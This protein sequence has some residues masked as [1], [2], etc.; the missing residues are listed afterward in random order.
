MREAALHGP[1]DVLLDHFRAPRFLGTLSLDAEDVGTGRAG[2]PEE[3]A[4]VRMQIRLGGAGPGLGGEGRVRDVRFK[5]FGCPAT[6]A[7]ASWT[8]ERVHGRP[9]VEAEALAVAEISRVLDLDPE[10]QRSAELAHSALQAAL[11]DLQERAPARA[12]AVT[13]SPPASRNPVS[14][15]PR[16]RPTRGER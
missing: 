13:G 1:S 11:R 3:G 5:A 8:A 2:R 15:Q 10:Q 14:F 6:I 7:C 9:V 16:S 12:C 4:L